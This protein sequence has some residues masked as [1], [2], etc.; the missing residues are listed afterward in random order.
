MTRSRMITIMA[1]ADDM[2]SHLL[3]GDY[4]TWRA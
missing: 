1:E 4:Q 2:S 3:V